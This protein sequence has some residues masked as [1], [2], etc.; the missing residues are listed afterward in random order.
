MAMRFSD[1]L[2]QVIGL[3]VRERR[4]TYWALKQE[5]GLDDAVLEGLREELIFAKR[6]ARDE[7]GKVLVW[8]ADRPATATTATSMSDVMVVLPPLALANNMPALEH[9]QRA[10]TM[11]P[12]IPD[13]HT[14]TNSHTPPHSTEAERRQVTVMFCDLVDSTRLSQQLDP[15]DY[16]TVVRAYQTAASEAVQLYDGYVAQYLGDGLMAYF[17][18][19]QAY[20]DAA[21]RAVH[22]SLAVLDAMG[23][24]NDRLAPQYGVRVEVRIGLHTGM[25]VIGEMGGGARQE[26]LAMG[27]TSNIASRI[28]GLAAPDTVVISAA[29]ARLVQ[30]TFDLEEL[31]VH[32]LKG[33][34]EPM[35]VFHVLGAIEIDGS[36]DETVVFNVPTLVGRD[37]EIGLLRRRW[38]Q[39]VDGLGQ[40]VLISGEAGIG[41]SS[42]VTVVRQQVGRA[43]VTRMTLRCSPYHTNSALYPVV[44]HLQRALRWQHDDTAEVKFDKL[45][46]ALSATQL[47]LAETV[48]LFAAL[49]GVPLAAERYAPLALPPPQQ[50]QQTYDALVAWML[51]EAERQP[52]LMVWEDV[53]WADPSTLELLGL[54]IEQM[55]T[56]SMLQV[57]TFR[58]EFTPPWPTRSHMTPITLNRLER[59]QV[60]AMITQQTGGKQLPV[61]VVEHIVA[62]TDGVPLY[63]EELTKM[64]LESDFLHEETDTYVLTGPLLSVAIPDTLQDS[65]MAR[66]DQ[67]DTAK[68]FA[69]LGAVLGREF[70]YE[71]LLAIAAQGEA[72][73]R[74]GL[75]QLVAAELLYQRG[76]PPRARYMFKHALIQDAAYASLLRST[77]QQVHRQIAE[78]LEARFPDVVETQPELVAHHYTEAACH[79][80]AIDHWQRAGQ[81]AVQ[82]SA[83]VEAAHHLTQG[84]TLLDA[85][86]ATPARAETELYLRTTLGPVLMATEGQA[87]PEVE[88]N[89][90]RARALCQQVGDTPQLFPVMWGLWRVYN[91]SAQFDISRELGEQLLALARRTREPTH[92]IAAHHALGFNLVPVGEYALGHEHLEQVQRHYDREHHHALI[93]IC[94]QDSGAT[95][96]AMDAWALWILGAPQQA[97]DRSQEAIRLAQELSHPL[98]LAWTLASAAMVRQFRGEVEATLELSDTVIVLSTEHHFPAWM[99]WCTILR[100]WS[101]V[102]QGRVAQGI[103]QMQQGGSILQNINFNSVQT[104]F[105]GLLADA[106]R[107]TGQMAE[108]LHQIDRALEAAVHTGEGFYVAELYRLKGEILFQQSAPDDQVAACFIQAL[109]I[110]RRQQARSWELRAAMSL[111]R[112][113]QRQ[114][115]GTE[116]RELLAPVYNGFSEGLDSADLREGK[117]LLGTLLDGSSKASG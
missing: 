53:H 103:E 67:L 13:A 56:V 101:L 14:A 69:Q 35:P 108:S 72:L 106:Y 34:A 83:Y 52:V 80:Q 45:E 36:E 86:P 42:L 29:T 59:P 105:A 68:A 30:H 85:L 18:W 90:A 66:L 57:L 97:L 74:S 78:Y 98:S 16:R 23:P 89:Y 76:R 114:G 7:G 12:E 8:A 5:F 109:E 71:M 96:L 40:V 64:L 51:E 11:S 55:P 49:L 21:V 54:F 61:E 110:A 48:P 115:K 15:E 26:Q 111:S 32:A 47:P 102:R 113:W 88:Q 73:V 60:E 19:P 24:L 27:D 112:L 22:A 93:A 70:D 62:K 17:G 79:A 31:G 107:Q 100:G 33:V 37:E 46:Q 20:E 28:E 58:P 75:A 25:A 77:R 95:C 63:V 117:A 94:A 9:D 10:A 81:R 65:L 91:V 82:R 39:S 92:L 2:N 3:L 38:E 1:I 41:K 116:A 87:A 99:A 50:R 6:V 44:E 4:I 104:Y 43:G 84:L